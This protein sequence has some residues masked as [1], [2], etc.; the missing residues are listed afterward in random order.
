MKALLVACCLLLVSAVAAAQEIT[1]RVMTFNVRYGTALDGD[2]AW[3]KR[4]DTVVNCIKQYDPDIVGTQEC[5]AMQADYIAANLPGYRWTG[6]GRDQNGKGEMTAVFYKAEALVPVETLNFWLSETPDQPGSM[7]WDTACTRMATR[8]KFHHPKTGR[9]L[10]YAN[11]HM[12]HKSEPARQNGIGVIE[13][14]LAPYAGDLPIILTGDF[15]SSAGKSKAYEFA[16]GKGFKDSWVEAP[17]KKGPIVTISNF[18]APKPEADERIDW[19][20][21]RGNAQALEC[22]TVTYNENGRYPT[23]HC[24]VFGVLRLP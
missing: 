24:P 22:E 17:E 13:A 10:V 15:N 1:L 21:Y 9:F 18:K 11:T 6:I 16:I 3:S 23:D 12:D 5:L 19:I 14:H 8:I 7:S 2:N 20:L 4:R